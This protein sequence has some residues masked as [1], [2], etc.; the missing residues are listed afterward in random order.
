MSVTSK[1]VILCFPE[2]LVPCQPGAQCREAMGALV[3]LSRGCRREVGVQG[4]VRSCLV[5]A[6]NF[7]GLSFLSFFGGGSF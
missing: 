4:T 3:R 1:Q 5:F 2:A 7:S 6:Q